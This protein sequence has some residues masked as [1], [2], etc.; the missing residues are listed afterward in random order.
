MNN[1]VIN[2]FSVISKYIKLYRNDSNQT[3]YDNDT[4]SGRGARDLNLG[5]IANGIWGTEVPR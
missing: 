3:K 4:S 2:R 5:A 1:F